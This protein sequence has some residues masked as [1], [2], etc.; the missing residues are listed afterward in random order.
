MFTGV[1]VSGRKENPNPKP[2]LDAVMSQAQLE[3]KVEDYL[4]NSQAVEDYYNEPLST[5]QLQG[6]MDRMA[7]DTRQPEVLRELFEALSDD[8][9]VIA[10]CLARPVLSERMI[11]SSHTT[12]IKTGTLRPKVMAAATVNYTLPKVSDGGNGCTD[13]TWS[14]TSVTNAPDVRNNHTAVWTGSEMII[15][16]GGDGSSSFGTGGRYNPSTDSWTPTSSVNAPDGRIGHTAIWTGSE[17]IVWGGLTEC[18]PIVYLNTG[19]RYNPSAD[20]WVAT[21][22]TGTPDGRS[23]HTAVWTGTEMIVWGDEV[24]VFI[25]P[26]ADT[27]RTPIV[28]QIPAP[29]MHL[30]GDMVIQP[31]GLAAK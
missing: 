3:K 5:D 1:T 20:S 6:E 19:G 22:I 4:V 14:P 13:D 11:T 2:S 27:I 26:A 17:M 7:R 25:A 30:A 9:F 28:G 8:P 10:E 23:S 12:E 16:G 31:F 15:W 29:R 18:C 21:T 24:P